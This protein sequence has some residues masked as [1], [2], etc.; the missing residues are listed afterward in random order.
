MSTSSILHAGGVAARNQGGGPDV[1]G[2]IKA[3][4]GEYE[5][6]AMAGLLPGKRT[7]ANQRLA[8]ILA[9]ERCA[10]WRRTSGWRTGT[11][12]DGT[13]RP[14]GLRQPWKPGGEPQKRSDKASF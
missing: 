1:A 2:A 6:G 12:D 13:W 10:G 8:M 3:L 4:P 14:A 7:A 5:T 9:W 11:T